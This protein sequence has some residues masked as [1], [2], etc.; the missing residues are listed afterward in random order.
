MS[1]VFESEGIPT[2][3]ITT[4]VPIASFSGAYRIVP[5][6]GIDR[7]LGDPDQPPKQ[8]KQIRRKIVRKAIEALETDI[9]GTAVFHWGEGY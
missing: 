6:C 5:A 2:A 3:L 1:K 7:P 8:E 9:T 4:L